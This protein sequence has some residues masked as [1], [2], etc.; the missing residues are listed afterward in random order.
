MGPVRPLD[1]AAAA[2]LAVDIERRLRAG[3]TLR[4]TNFMTVGKFNVDAVRWPGGRVV[5]TDAF[6]RTLGQDVDDAARDIAEMLCE[7]TLAIAGEGSAAR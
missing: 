6:G 1:A 3:E 7:G 2:T 4:F 5:V